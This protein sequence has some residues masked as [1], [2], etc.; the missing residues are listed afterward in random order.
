MSC[1]LSCFYRLI[2]T[3]WLVSCQLSCFYRLI[4]TRDM[5]NIMSAA[6][7]FPE[8]FPGTNFQP[9]NFQK[10]SGLVVSV[11]TSGLDRPSSYCSVVC[12]DFSKVTKT[13]CTLHK[14]RIP[15]QLKIEVSRMSHCLDLKNSRLE[16]LSTKKEYL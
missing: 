13:M 2:S 14:M 1:P 12:L 6:F 3:L 10:Q 11:F 8:H 4:G 15:W 5:V 7:A 16:N 9:D